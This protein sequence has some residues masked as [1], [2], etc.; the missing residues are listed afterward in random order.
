VDLKTGALRPHNPN[1]LITKLAPHKFNPRARYKKFARFIKQAT[2]NNKYLIKCLRRL[3]GYSLTGEYIDHVFVVLFGPGATGKSTLLRVLSCVLGDYACST[4]SET[5]YEK[6]LAGSDP[7]PDLVRLRGMRMTWTSE[8]NPNRW[9]DAARLKALTGGDRMVVRQL[10]R[11][12][13]EFPPQAKLWLAANDRPR[14]RDTDEALWRRP[15]V[16]PFSA[17]VPAEEQDRRLAEKLEK[18]AEGILRWAVGG[19]KL[20]YAR[21]LYVPTSVKNAIQQFRKNYDHV[22]R[23]AT[24]AIRSDENQVT[25]AAELF[26]RYC[27][28]CGNHSEEPLSIKSFKLRLE[29]EGFKHKRVKEGSVWPGISIKP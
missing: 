26:K 15:I 7:R 13:E 29:R 22:R 25:G 4:P 24:E 21:G 3:I 6:P 20:W 8:A 28:W 14:I 16:I 2:G 9:L 11:E 27:E 12:F 23:F 19:A 18:E 10:Y 1:D 17:P 5:L